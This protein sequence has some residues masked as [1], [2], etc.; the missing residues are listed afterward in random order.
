[1]AGNTATV[2]HFHRRWR[3]TRSHGSGQSPASGAAMLSTSCR[4]E[5]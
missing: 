1:M 4:I 2:G 5:P 3:M